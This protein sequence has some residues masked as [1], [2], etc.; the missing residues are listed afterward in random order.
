[1]RFTSLY[2]L[3]LA[4]LLCALAHVGQAQDLDTR[5]RLQ[6]MDPNHNV[7]VDATIRFAGAPAKDSCLGGDWKRVVVEANTVSDERFFPLGGP[8]AYSTEDGKLTF[9]RTAVCDN[10]LLLSGA[11]GPTSMRG[12]YRGAGLRGGERLGYFSLTRLQ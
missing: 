10:Y 8:L 12:S 11:R 9:G 7:K 4:A 1:M 2:K 5:W 3:P 6:V